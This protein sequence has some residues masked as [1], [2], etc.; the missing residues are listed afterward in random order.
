MDDILTLIT[1]TSTQDE[2][3]ALIEKEV[4]TNV[5]AQ[6]RSVSRS[7]FWNAGQKGLSPSLV[8]V[9]RYTNYDDQT[10][11]IWEGKRYTIYRTYFDGHD[12]IELYL[13][14]QAYER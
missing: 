8:A 5:F 11:A 14:V 1:K 13:E 6:V 3:G 7:E 12:D 9:T 2:I 4:K 10:E